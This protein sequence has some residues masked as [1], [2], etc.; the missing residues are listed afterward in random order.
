MSERCTVFKTVRPG[1]PT[2]RC[3]NGGTHEEIWSGCPCEDKDPEVCLKD[4]WGSSWECDG[5]HVYGADDE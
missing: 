1:E 3:L 5:P 2:L 4:G